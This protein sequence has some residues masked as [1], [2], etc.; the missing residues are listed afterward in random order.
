MEIALPAEEDGAGR[1]MGQAL[2]RIE[3]MSPVTMG[4]FFLWD[5][6]HALVHWAGSPASDSYRRWFMCVGLDGRTN[7]LA[8]LN[9]LGGPM[10]TAPLRSMAALS[11][12]DTL[13]L[14]SL[15]QWAASTQ[16][17]ALAIPGPIINKSVV[18]STVSNACIIH[19]L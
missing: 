1:G 11:T 6:F 2:P 3:S 12:T 8:V 16:A 9:L 14:F 18:T 7:G 17:P 4:V 10:P 5:H 19:P 13:T 15:A